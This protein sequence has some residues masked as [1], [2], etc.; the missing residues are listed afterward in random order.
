MEPY[1]DSCST[2]GPSEHE[3]VLAPSLLFYVLA[4]ITCCLHVFSTIIMMAERRRLV[5]WL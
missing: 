2:Y 5:S 4:I 1:F 3:Q